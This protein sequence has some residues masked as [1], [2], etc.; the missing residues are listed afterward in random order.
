MADAP[1]SYGHWVPTPLPWNP[2]A[3]RFGCVLVPAPVLVLVQL[4]E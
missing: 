2:A 3:G 1:E 4:M